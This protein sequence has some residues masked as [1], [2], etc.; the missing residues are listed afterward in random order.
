MSHNAWLLFG[1]LLSKKIFL[2][3]SSPFNLTMPWNREWITS[4]IVNETEAWQV[5]LAK[6][7]LARNCIIVQL[8]YN[9]LHSS[10]LHNFV[11]NPRCVLTLKDNQCWN[12]IWVVE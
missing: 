8:S 2:H 5:L 6:G 4:R 9:L 11:A 3:T 12:R 7:I 10:K 1:I